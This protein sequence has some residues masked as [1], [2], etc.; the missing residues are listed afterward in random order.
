MTRRKA[1]IGLL[2]AG[3]AVFL[4]ITLEA[5][6]YVA[7]HPH[8]DTGLTV[9]Y[10]APWA[11]A[12]ASSLAIAGVAMALVPIRRGEGWAWGTSVAMWLILLVTRF[13]S[14]PRCLVVLD[15]H[16]HGCHS[17][18]IAAALAIVGLALAFP[19]RR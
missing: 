8:H 15:A 17:F 3:Y 7:A 1:G 10:A 13:A 14:D 5:P 9:A 16:Q 2:L 4:F 19:G 18:M 12:T 11:V 6:F